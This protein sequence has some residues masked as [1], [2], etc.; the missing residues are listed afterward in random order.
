MNHLNGAI[1]L[2]NSASA[3]GMAGRKTKKI[4]RINWKITRY[5]PLLPH[6]SLSF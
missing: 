4:I 5:S 1:D 6:E 2:N 3:Q